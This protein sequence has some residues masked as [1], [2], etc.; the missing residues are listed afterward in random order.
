MYRMTTLSA[1][2]ESLFHAPR[3]MLAG[4]RLFLDPTK[5]DMVFE[6][7]RYGDKTGLAASVAQLRGHDSARAAF[8]SRRRLVVDVARLG[9]LPPAT[10]GRTFVDYLADNGL[11][12]KELPTLPANDDGEY[13]SAHLTE[14]H[15]LWHVVTGFR[16]DVAGELG[17]Q[18]V[19]AAQIGGGLP[20][21]ILG[22]GL[23][24]S[25]LRTPDDFS[26]RLD[27]IVEGWRIG[28]QARCLFGVPWDEL[29]EQPLE[30]VRR[31][32]GVRV[33]A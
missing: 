2:M 32:L 3:T 1:R 10:L 24:Q 30:T 21:V 17:L 8:D 14:T 18:A 25:A 28:R 7:N 20:H 16:T 31:D 12:P 26:R 29:W 6:L 9:A 19:Y 15:D 23:L 27:A 13:L 22:G 4:I 5:T 33:A 11:D